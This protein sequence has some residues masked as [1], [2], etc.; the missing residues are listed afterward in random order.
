VLIY[1][2]HLQLIDYCGGV[3][4]VRGLHLIFVSK[5]ALLFPRLMALPHTETQLNVT[6]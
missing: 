6:S 1:R 3:Y 4:A 5:S 2:C